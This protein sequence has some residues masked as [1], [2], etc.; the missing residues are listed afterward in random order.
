VKAI[1]TKEGRIF[2][3]NFIDLLIGIVVVFLLFNF[4]SE[5][6]EEE[7]TYSGDEMYNAIQDYTSLDLKGFL[8][9]AE[10]EGEWITDET[11]FNGRGIITET[12]SGSFV[13]KTP[14]GK[15]LRIGGSMGYFEDIATSKLRFRPVDNYVTTLYIEPRTFS[16]YG[17][18]ID[19]FKGIKTEYQADHVLISMKHVT[20]LNPAD[21]S[22]KIFNEF[23]NLYLL[24]YIGI[25]QTSESEATFMIDLAE[26]SELEKIDIASEGV[27]TGKIEAHLGYAAEPNLGEELHVAS[28][29]DILR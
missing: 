17:E 12:R 16:N 6:F 29:E 23:D 9:E 7:L 28:I 19:Y 8:V 10:I 5:Y 1:D 15:N 14:D 26:L 20:F 13:V 4:G 27:V 3:V 22:Q 21:S 18:M 2:G 25:D 11:K 24:K